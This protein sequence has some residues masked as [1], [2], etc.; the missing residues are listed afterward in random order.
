M[1]FFLCARNDTGLVTAA[2]TPEAPL[3]FW[4]T[5]E[6]SKLEMPA[7]PFGRV[8]KSEPALFL[9]WGSGPMRA[10]LSLG[11]ESLTIG[12][13]AFDV[14][15]AGRIYLIDGEQDRLAVFSDGTL[16]RE[17]PLQLE[18]QGDVAVTADGT[19]HVLDVRNGVAHVQAIPA[20]GVAPPAVPVGKALSSHIRAAGGSAFVNL[21]PTDAWVRVPTG[22]DPL[23]SPFAGQLA[24]GH[25]IGGDAQLLRVGSSTAVRLAGVSGERLSNAVEIRSEVPLGDVALA[26][27]DGSGGYLCVVRVWRGGPSPADQY[28]VLHIKRGKVVKTF[29]V[30]SEQYADTPPLSTFRLGRDGDLYQLATGPSGFRIFRFDL[31]E[32]A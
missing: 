2:G 9:P 22:R 25:P 7:I 31:G 6:M 12:P 5:T 4:V 10:G 17:A 15:E 19:A 30:S 16:V 13:S 24:V 23:P 27:P 1:R 26:E 20:S 28:Q 32:E 14:D 21:L 3:R 11:R 29:A 8:R 18:S